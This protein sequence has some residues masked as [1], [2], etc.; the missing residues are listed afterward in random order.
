MKLRRPLAV[1]SAAFLA[2]AAWR[3][4]AQPTYIAAAGPGRPGPRLSAAARNQLT[5]H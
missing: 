3:D 4:S 5:A 2:Q 1:A